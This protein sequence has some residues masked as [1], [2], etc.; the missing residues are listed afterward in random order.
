MGPRIVKELEEGLAAGLSR[1][2]SNVVIVCLLVVRGHDDGAS[3]FFGAICRP[4]IRV[5]W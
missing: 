5:W 3:T 2:P 1:W 4:T